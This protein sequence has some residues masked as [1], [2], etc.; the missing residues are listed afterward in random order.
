MA[1]SD[2]RGYLSALEDAGQLV[3][4][5]QLVD[6]EPDLRAVGRAALNLGVSGS[7]AVMVT[8]IRGYRG[9]RVVLNV[10]GS[11]ANYAVM[12]GMPKT[13]SLREMFCEMNARWNSYP[14]EVRWVHN[15]PCQEEVIT[16][17]INLYELLPLFRIN[18]YDGGFYLSKACIVSKDPTD[19]DNFDRQNVGTYRLQVQG[20]D[21]LGMQALPFH[22][23]GVH[24]RRAEER[25]QPLPIAICLGV[26]PMLTC[27]SCTPLAY[28][29]SEFKYAA[30]LNGAPQELTKC[31]TCDLDVPAGAEYVI[32]GEV[33]PR[34]RFPEGPFGEFPGS[35]SGIRQQVRIKVKAVT[36][37]RDPIFENLY[38]G[39]PWTEHDTLIGLST[40]VPLYQQL[41]ETFPEVTAVNALYQHGLTVIVACSNRFGG[42]AK[43]VAMRVASTP[44]G[45]SYAKN[46][47]VV[48]GAVDP[49]DLDQVMWALST[50]VR[51]DKDVI[52][53]PHT[54]GMPLDPASDPPGM[55]NKLIIDATTPAPPEPV[56][57]EVRMLGDVE[58]AAHFE[59]LLKEAMAR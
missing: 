12:M 24:L 16:S 40:S 45:I 51:A 1:F 34:Q 19:P 37:R 44:H 28:D 36:H 55:G 29:L 14:G 2:L 6:P 20:P 17:G 10:H 50:R 47:I 27:M 57:R 53:V 54:P 18:E 48:D 23:I 11:W 30:A 15:A 32:E 21:T 39:R 41:R 52:V 8:N 56:M 31:L 33:L 4:V 58:K 38:I 26:E 46:I 49:F 43:S 42:Y 59:R 7:P 13:A 35:Y 9:K 22:D 3:T 5:D 25:N